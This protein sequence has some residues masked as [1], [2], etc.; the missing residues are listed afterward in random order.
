[1]EA[2]GGE[3]RPCVPKEAGLTDKGGKAGIPGLSEALL[4]FPFNCQRD[5][6][7]KR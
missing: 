1:M 6:E 2:S 5:Q 4:P 7:R 3:G